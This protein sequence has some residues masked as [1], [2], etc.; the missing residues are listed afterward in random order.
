VT[1][2]TLPLPSPVAAT[3]LQS[4][5][6][7]RVYRGNWSV[8]P[9]FS[10]LEC[11]R[12][13]RCTTIDLAAIDAPVE[14]FGAGFTGLLRVPAEDLYAFYTTSDDGSRLW[15]GDRLLVDNDGLHPAL[16]R[17]GLIRLPAGLHPIRI[18]FFERSG[19]EGLT[20]AWESPTIPKEKLPADVL[21]TPR[22]PTDDPAPP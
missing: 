5:L 17:G 11:E 4:G 2:A 6:E 20:V 8:L 21:F 1:L 12:S 10:T 3:D 16:E 22:S 7:F 19:A 15:I 14:E 9:D 18:E 13:G